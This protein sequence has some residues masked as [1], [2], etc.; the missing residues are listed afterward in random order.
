MII[1]KGKDAECLS[2][3]FDADSSITFPSLEKSDLPNESIVSDLFEVQ[4]DVKST[5][6]Y[7][8][9]ELVKDTD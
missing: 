3:S 7:C 9:N 5:C 2:Y 1:V 8:L 6:Q 4:F